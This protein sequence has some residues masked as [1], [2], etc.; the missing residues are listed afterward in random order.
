MQAWVSMVAD[1]HRVGAAGVSCWK[2]K[3]KFPSIL[4]L[5]IL[6]LV[7]GTFSTLICLYPG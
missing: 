1:S 2:L 6:G 4:T 7:L 3:L 5:F